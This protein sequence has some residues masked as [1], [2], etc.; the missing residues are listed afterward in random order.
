MDNPMTASPPARGVASAALLLALMASFAAAAPSHGI[1]FFS[2][3]TAPFEGPL[4]SCLLDEE[5]GSVVQCLK[6]KAAVALERAALL[7]TVPLGAGAALVKRTGEADDNEVEENAVASYGEDV[8]TRLVGGVAR[9]LKG[10]ALR[11]SLPD[12]LVP[13]VTSSL[14]EGRLKKHK[15]LG[16][17]ITCIAVV[18][19]T[20]ALAS[21]AFMAKKALLLGKISLLL[22]AAVLMKKMGG[23]GHGGTSYEVVSLHRRASHHLPNA[24]HGEVYGS[25]YG[26]GGAAGGGGADDREGPYGTTYAVL[27]RA[28]VLGSDPRPPAPAAAAAAAPDDPWPQFQME[29][30]RS[31]N[32]AGWAHWALPPTPSPYAPPSA[33]GQQVKIS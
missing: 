21:I 33:L 19:K 10:R 31:N 17:L 27:R 18:L 22:S 6:E 14:E 11:L 30:P 4:R 26:G 7:D 3:A 24:H 28:K 25:A 23:G 16:T 1:T 9:L 29:K 12:N 8:D 2:R 15:H 32:E 5:R 13:M 20:L